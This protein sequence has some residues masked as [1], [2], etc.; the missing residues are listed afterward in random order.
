MLARNNEAYAHFKHLNSGTV[1]DG[2]L[3]CAHSRFGVDPNNCTVEIW[4]VAE[5]AL[6]HER[7]IRMPRKYG[8]L[9]WIDRTIDGS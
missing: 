3:Y 2:K 9:T 6:A 5:K 1:V 4:N 8:S 7:T